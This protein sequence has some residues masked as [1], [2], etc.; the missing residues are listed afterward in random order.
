MGVMGP[1]AAVASQPLDLKGPEYAPPFLSVQ[2]GDIAGS[3]CSWR[4]I[5]VRR[6]PAARKRI[7]ILSTIA[8]IDAGFGRFTSWIWP[9]EP[10]SRIMWFL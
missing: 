4:G 1:W 5:A 10:A 6:N 3:S 9:A 7:M 8:P 2:L